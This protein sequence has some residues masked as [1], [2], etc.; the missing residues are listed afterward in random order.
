[1]KLLQILWTMFA[2]M[3]YPSHYGNGVYGLK[4]SD[5]EPY[6]TVYYSTLD[7]Q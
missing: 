7:M 2:L 3:Q 1:M 5:V 6:K 4:V